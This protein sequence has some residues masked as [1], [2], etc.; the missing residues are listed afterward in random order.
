M[1]ISEKTCKKCKQTL[2]IEYFWKNPSIKDGYFNKCKPCAS[3]VNTE[4]AVKNQRFL[5]KNLW[6]CSTCSKELELTSNNF[7]KRADSVTGFQHRCK[8][9]FQKTEAK[10]IRRKKK[11]DLKYFIKDLFFGAKNRAK[12]KNLDFN[13][14]IDFL[15]NLYVE[16]SGKCALTGIK[17]RHTILEGKIKTNISID[18][19]DATKGYIETNVQ[20]VCSI[21][22]TMKSDMSLEDLKYYC[23]LILNNHE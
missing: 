8:K 22:N 13:L 7:Y 2:S 17:M 11:G 12:R 9:C 5:N 15:L 10:V 20:L 3:K 4:N 23:T 19:I 16:Q 6:T 18:K 1:L 21:V 14:T